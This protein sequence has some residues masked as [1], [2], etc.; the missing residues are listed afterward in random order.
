M[1]PNDIQILFG[2]IFGDILGGR[3]EKGIVFLKLKKKFKLELSCKNNMFYP[4][5]QL[6][7]YKRRGL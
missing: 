2:D 4:I 5:S 6:F 3:K 1:S 7:E